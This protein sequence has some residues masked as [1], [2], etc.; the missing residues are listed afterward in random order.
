MLCLV[1]RVFFGGSTCVDDV[2]TL[3]AMGGSARCDVARRDNCGI[4][5]SAS[6]IGIRK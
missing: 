4:K 3:P 1:S 5:I 2:E 6:V